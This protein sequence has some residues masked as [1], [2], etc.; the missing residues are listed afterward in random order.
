MIFKYLVFENDSVVVFF[1]FSM[2]KPK[3]CYFY[4]ASM[5]NQ[6]N[7]LLV[8]IVQFYKTPEKY[9]KSQSNIYSA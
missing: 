1:G 9:K 8:C 3:I 6:T 7:L 5:N 4:F 2:Q